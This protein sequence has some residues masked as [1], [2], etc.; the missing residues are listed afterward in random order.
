MYAAVRIPAE[1]PLVPACALTLPHPQPHAPMP[2]GRHLPL[3]DTATLSDL[4]RLALIILLLT[5]FMLKLIVHRLRSHHA[6]TRHPVRLAGPCMPVRQEMY[7]APSRARNAPGFAA[8][9]PAKPEAA[10]KLN[11]N[12]VRPHAHAVDVE[13]GKSGKNWSGY[14]GSNRDTQLGR[15]VHYHYAIP[16]SDAVTIGNSAAT[17]EGNVQKMHLIGKRARPDSAHPA[18]ARPRWTDCKLH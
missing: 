11:W 14:T 7:Q 5:V 10:P 18:A 1:A 15:L 3:P 12:K 13:P 16:A 9:I 8:R 4:K 6:K 2:L 17:Q